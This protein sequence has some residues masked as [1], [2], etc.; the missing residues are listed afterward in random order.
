MDSRWTPGW[1]KTL[2]DLVQLA[3]M[4]SKPTTVA[5]HTPF[6][7]S[8]AQVAARLRRKPAGPSGFAVL[9]SLAQDHF[10]RSPKGDALTWFHNF[11]VPNDTPF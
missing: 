2:L 7:Y 10:D 11:G 6:E 4:P 9:L 8:F 1:D 3:I 5:L